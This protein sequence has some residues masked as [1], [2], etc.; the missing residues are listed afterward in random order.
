MTSIMADWRTERQTCVPV[1]V[2]EC[3][4]D[5]VSSD[6]FVEGR[7]APVPGRGAGVSVSGTSEIAFD[8]SLRCLAPLDVSVGMRRQAYV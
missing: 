1:Y 2:R 3:L 7:T 5:S 6:H 8:G 4:F